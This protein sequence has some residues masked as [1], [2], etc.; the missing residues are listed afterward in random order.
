MST[1]RVNVVFALGLIL[2]A[3]CTLRGKPTEADRYHRPEEVLEF[4]TLYRDN[5]AACHGADGKLGPGPP[6]R[7][8][9]FRALI[10]TAEVEKVVSHGRTGTLMPAFTRKNGGIL[11]ETQVQ[12]LV[13]EIKGIAYKVERDAAGGVKVVSDHNGVAP[14]WGIPGP[15]KDAPSYLV[16]KKP[17]GDWQRGAKIFQTACATCHGDHGLGTDNG[18][19]IND[20]AFLTLNSDQILRRYIITGRSDLHMPDYRD[21]EG[22]SADFVPLTS[23]QIA[24]LTAL[25]AFWRTGESSSDK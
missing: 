15:M 10:P 16:E 8:D 13:H 24:D 2:A 12:I 22:R 19:R 20:A 5:C 14:S 25:L 4:A 23:E 1:R 17:K 6:L 9:L 18:L 11:T 21:H 7:D 3:G